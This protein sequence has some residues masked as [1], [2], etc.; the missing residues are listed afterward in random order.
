MEETFKKLNI[1]IIYILPIYRTFQTAF[2]ALENHPNISNIKARIHPLIN[3]AT[4]CIQDYKL[5]IKK[6][7]TEFNMN[8][9][10]TLIEVFL[11]IL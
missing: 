5:D 8:P 11:M 7:K 10:I 1:E 3:E 2:Y 9:K 4:S 6:S